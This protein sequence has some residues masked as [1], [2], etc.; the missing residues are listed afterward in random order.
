MSLSVEQAKELLPLPELM[1]LLGFGDA[2]ARSA[3]CPFHEDHHPSFSVFQHGG[4][5]F[6]KC[7][8]GC[9]AGDEIQF[10]AQAESLDAPSA[11]HR[12]LELA[13]LSNQERL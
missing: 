8:A 7:H 5:W 11:I 2:C 13:T 4:S 9:G 1:E 10:I 3:L 12:Y 6:W